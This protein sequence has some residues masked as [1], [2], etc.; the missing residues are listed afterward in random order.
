MKK[1]SIIS[2]LVCAAACLASL[3]ANAQNLI[4]VAPVPEIYEWRIY[5]LAPEADAAAL[6]AFFRDRL[7][8]AYGRHGIEVGAFS[9]AE[10][11]SEFPNG[12]RY[13][14]F[15]WPDLETFRRVNRL[16]R[17]DAAFMAGAAAYFD[18][19][20]TNPNYTNFET[21]LCEAL[22]SH[23]RLARPAADRGLLEF[24][25]YRSPNIEANERKIHMFENG[26]IDIFR[27]TGVNGVFYSRTLAGTRMPSLTYLTWYKDADTRREAWNR[28]G[29]HP[30]WRRMSRMPEY[31]HTATDNVIR[32]L[33]P[34]PYSKY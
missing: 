30:E 2:L 23:P 12:A 21:Y 10:S 1:T 16:V 13:L 19:S 20:A 31:A 18:A 28:F 7:I 17:E 32:L 22:D 29:A 24:R 25:I 4:G 26:E 11:Y 33:T 6:D 5:T 3:S 14:F 34:L 15:A 27:E 8:P 9:P